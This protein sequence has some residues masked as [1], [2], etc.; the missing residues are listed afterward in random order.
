MS[1]LQYESCGRPLS[2]SLYFNFNM[3]NLVNGYVSSVSLRLFRNWEGNSLLYL[4]IIYV[5]NSYYISDRYAI[6]PQRNTTEWQI[7]KIPSREFPIFKGH[8]LAIGMQESSD[9]NQIY[10]IQ[11]GFAVYGNVMNVNKDTIQIRLNHTASMGIAYGYTVGYNDE[12]K[13]Y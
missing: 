9:T 4:F 6:Q 8:F 1:L 12:R 7:I 11:S 13:F 3:M 5:N 2:K 10:A